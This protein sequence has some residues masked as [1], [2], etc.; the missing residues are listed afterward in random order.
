MT[1]LKSKISVKQLHR[2]L[3]DKLDEISEAVTRARKPTYF[4]LYL[5]GNKTTLKQTNNIKVVGELG[6]GKKRNRRQK[7]TI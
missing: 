7:G 6:E 2:M 5:N 3:A 1:G 4:L